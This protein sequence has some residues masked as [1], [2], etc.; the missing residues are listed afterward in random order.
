MKEH[1]KVWFHCLKWSI[2]PYGRLYPPHRMITK[3]YLQSALGNRKE[4]SCECGYG[5]WTYHNK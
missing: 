2:W 1:I 5:T 3:T 4:Y